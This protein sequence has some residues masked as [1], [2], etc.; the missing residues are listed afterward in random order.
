M[1]FKASLDLFSTEGNFL[2]AIPWVHN[3]GQCKFS[4]EAFLFFKVHHY[5][6]F[7]INT[8]MGKTCI[9]PSV[10]SPGNF[11]VTQVGHCLLSVRQQGATMKLR[12]FI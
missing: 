3:L 6:T 11:R 2:I 12:P 9:G 5:R 1:H 7:P 4:I 10:S 8:G